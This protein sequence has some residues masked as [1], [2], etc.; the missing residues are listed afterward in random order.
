[1][2]TDAPTLKLIIDRWAFMEASRRRKGGDLGAN[3]LRHALLERSAYELEE[4]SPDRLVL[5][6]GPTGQRYAGPV[7]RELA[8]YLKRFRGGELI[9]E[10]HTF[11]LTLV[12][13]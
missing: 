13:I 10:D 6:F 7:P 2:P 4:C 1:M 5:V 9:R 12:S 8:D 3:P 11:E